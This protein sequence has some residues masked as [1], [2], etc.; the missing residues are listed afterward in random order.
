MTDALDTNRLAQLIAAKRQVLELLGQLSRRQLALIDEG[1]MSDLLKLLASKQTVLSQLQLLERK[2]DPFRAEDPERRSWRSPD[3]RA[4]CQA[5]IAACEALLADAV[6]LEKQSEQ[7]M[8]LRRDRAALALEEVQ[9]S[10]DAQHAYAMP[11]RSPAP[12]QME[13]QG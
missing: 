2:L 10:A 7:A 13:F 8:L 11:P 6:R 3:E 1:A 4:Q 5:A 12:P 9:A